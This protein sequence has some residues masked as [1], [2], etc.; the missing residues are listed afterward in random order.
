PKTQ[1]DTLIEIEISHRTLEE[2]FQLTWDMG[3]GKKFVHNRIQINVINGQLR[4]YINDVIKRL[5]VVNTL[6]SFDVNHQSPQSFNS[7]TSVSLNKIPSYD[8][9]DSKENVIN[10]NLFEEVK[11]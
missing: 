11:V 6:M 8:I 4:A 9:T 10:F 5:T 2:K 1:S 3:N 7:I